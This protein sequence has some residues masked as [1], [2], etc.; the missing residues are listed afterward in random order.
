VKRQIKEEEDDFFTPIKELIIEGFFYLHHK[1]KYP[2]SALVA[3]FMMFI[4]PPAFLI[5][6]KMIYEAEVTNSRLNLLKKRN[7][8]YFSVYEKVM[9]PEDYQDLISINFDSIGKFAGAHAVYYIKHLSK[10]RDYLNAALRRNGL[11]NE[12]PYIQYEP[13]VMMTCL[14]LEGDLDPDGKGF[15]SMF[16]EKNE[17][18]LNYSLA[19]Y[20]LMDEMQWKYQKPISPEALI[21]TYGDN[22]KETKRAG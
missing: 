17:R 14:K 11:N 4:V 15:Q 20:G 8:N 12:H 18:R 13:K 10:N 16:L 22:R 21:Q 7:K 5:A 2:F 1:E 19:Y 3:F 6:L 9:M